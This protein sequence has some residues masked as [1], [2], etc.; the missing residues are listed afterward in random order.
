M[1]IKQKQGTVE[2]F[3]ARDKL[4][5]FIFHQLAAM[6]LST[7]HIKLAHDL[8]LMQDFGTYGVVVSFKIPIL[9][10][11]VRFPVGAT[12]SSKLRNKSKLSDFFLHF[13][14]C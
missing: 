3:L 2:S 11:R 5:L 12:S 1:Q 9:E 4:V 6:R 8:R 13:F 10:T 14:A 7:I